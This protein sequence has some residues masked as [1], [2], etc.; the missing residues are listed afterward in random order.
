MKPVGSKKGN[1][2]QERVYNSLKS[3]IIR[4]EVESN[5]RL[6]EEELAERMQTS[7]TPVRE[8]FQKLEKEG[9]LER[10]PKVGYAVKGLYENDAE[11]LFEVR[12]V[13]DC[14]AGFLAAQRATA[15]EIKVLEEIVR[16]ERESLQNLQ[17]MDVDDFITSDNRFH[18]CIYLASKDQRLYR[19]F[20]DIR[21]HMHRY[22]AFILRYRRKPER[23]IRAHEEIVEAIIAGNSK[24]VE[25]L[26]R[27]HSK[28]TKGIVKKYIRMGK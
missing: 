28:R 14:Y 18:D 24:K 16:Q 3:A 12:T 10:R 26:M 8:A 17:N 4:G 6:V 13:L 27:S 2:L 15:E 20:S 19:L 5:T 7:R 23:A 25:R 9:F 22:R 11:E 1:S 21:D